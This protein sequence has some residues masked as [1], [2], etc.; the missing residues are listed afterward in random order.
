M[1]RFMLAAIA[2]LTLPVQSTWAANVLPQDG[3][4]ITVMTLRAEKSS[5][6]ILSRSDDLVKFPAM[7]AYYRVAGDIEKSNSWI[8]RCLNDE[9]VQ[10][11]KG[12]GALYLCLSL[13]AGNQLADGDIS[14][15]AKS[16][17]EVQKNYRSNIKPSLKPGDG[18]YLIESTDFSK[19]L[20]WPAMESANPLVGKAEALP[21]AMMAGIPIVS[22]KIKDGSDGKKRDVDVDFVVDTGS[23]R[24]VISEEVANRLGLKFTTGFITEPLDGGRT[25][26]FSLA[27]PVNIELGGVAIRDVSFSVSNDIKLN[28]IGLDILRKLG[29]VM[30]SSEKFEMLGH[31]SKTDC[32]NELVY[33]SLLWGIPIMP[34]LPGIVNGKEALIFLDTGSST[35]VDASGISLKGFPESGIMKKRIVDIFG[36]REIKYATSPIGVTVAGSSFT[37]DA[38]IRDQKAVALPI[39][40]RIGSKILESHTIYFDA[41]NGLA[42]INKVH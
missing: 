1:N 41:R 2:T 32:G 26:D 9:A 38:E 34:R 22:V 5:L 8:Q 24:S 17:L 35:L 40:W 7:A 18:N 27:D 21:I 14:G 30:L 39:S 28:L 13:S 16:M 3:P 29:P 31:N 12:E 4:G 33:S 6:Q 36:S 25:I 15:W 37:A 10:K 23:T 11:Q 19:F 20:R 42:C